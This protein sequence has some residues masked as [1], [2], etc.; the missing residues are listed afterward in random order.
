MMRKT[1]LGLLAAAALGMTALLPSA[2]SAHG[3]HGFHG[4]H[5]HHGFFGFGYG[6]AYVA[7]DGCLVREVV[8]TRR[9]PRVRLV[10]ACGY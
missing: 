10:N 5:H 7:D 8:E 1:T 3:F 2:A 4:W 9:G 6:P